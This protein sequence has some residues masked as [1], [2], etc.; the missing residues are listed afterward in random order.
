MAFVWLGQVFSTPGPCSQVRSTPV[1]C[2]CL[3]WFGCFVG[4]FCLRLFYCCLFGCF[5]RSC[6]YIVYLLFPICTMSCC[7]VCSWG[8]SF[9]VPSPVVLLF[10]LSGRV[11]SLALWAVSHICHWVVFFFPSVLVWGSFLFFGHLSLG[12]SCLFLFVQGFF[13]DLLAHPM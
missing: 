1:F 12:G 3:H 10:R 8:G 4:W 7:I 6:C 11:L 13:G 2:F 9:P 5:L